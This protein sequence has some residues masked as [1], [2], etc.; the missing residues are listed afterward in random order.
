MN[1]IQRFV[2]FL[3][4]SWKNLTFVITLIFARFWIFFNK[5]VRKSKMFVILKKYVDCKKNLI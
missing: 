5:N 3:Q 1:L 2:S 4:F